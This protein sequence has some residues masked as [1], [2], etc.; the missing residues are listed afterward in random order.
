MF[1]KRAWIPAIAGI[2]LMVGCD[3]K[4]SDKIP[5]TA[6]MAAKEPHEI[7]A[8]L[9][10]LAVRKDFKD[11]PVIAPSDLTNLYGNAFWFHSYAGTMN[12]SL[13][14]EEIQGLGV[15]ALADLGY[16]APGV[17]AMDLQG[18]QDKVGAKLL[19][20]LPPEMEKLNPDKLDKL[21]NN[22]SK[23][24]TIAKDYATV[25]DPALLRPVFNAGIYRLMK[26]V[27]ADMWS[28]IVV[29]EVKPNAGSA[30]AKDVFLGYKG[31]SIMQITVTP[32]ADGNYGIIY[33][34]FKVHVKTLAKMMADAKA[35]K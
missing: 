6:P 1:L 35:G 30:K 33:I 5:T 2:A 17:S 27:P 14:S 15:S 13:T 34:Y 29:M 8:H 32:K 4:P 18:A 26:G 7:L 25:S 31:T 24:K 12:L 21:P 16:I 11:L 28:D 19:P 22:Q 3:S 23:D 9:K 20:K 10:Y